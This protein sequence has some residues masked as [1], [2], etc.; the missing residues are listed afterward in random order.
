MNFAELA[1]IFEEIEGKSGRLEMT[2][3]LAGMFKKTNPEEAEKI[4]YLLQGQLAPPYMGLNLGLGERFAIEAISQS[5]GY[6]KNVVEKKYKEIGDLG[7]VAE[8]LLK[9]KKQMSLFAKQLSVL[10]VY[11]ILVKIAKASGAGSQE[12]KIKMLVELLNNSKPVEAKYIIRIVLGRLRLGVGDPTIL[13]GLSVALFG[14]KE[15][16][17]E[18][19]RA[20]NLCSDLGYVVRTAM[21]DYKKISRFKIQPFKPLMPALA[22]RLASAEEIIKKIGRCAV[23]RKYDGFRMQ[24]HK[25][26]INV[27]IY[28]R[29]LDVMTPMFPDVV[30]AIKKLKTNEIIFEGEALAFNKKKNRF[31]SFQETM[32]RRRKYGIDKASLEFPLYVFVFDLLYLNGEDYT[33]KPY[34]ERR[35]AL[36]KVFPSGILEVA[37]SIETDNPKK[38]EEFFNDSINKGLEGIVAKDLNAPYTA[39][40]RKFAWIKLKKSYGKAVDTVDAVIVGYYLGKGARAEFEFGGLLVAVR[41]EDS[42]KLE[43]IAKIGSGYTEEEMRMLKE[44]LSEIKTKEPPEDLVYRIKPDFWVE[45]KYVIEV[46]FDE[47]TESPLHTAGL[48]GEKGYALRFPRMVRLRNDKAPDEATTTREIEEMFGI[49]R[50]K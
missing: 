11:D 39:G 21:E 25:K 23:E 13:D 17:E 30:N 19:E 42:G 14:T 29:R 28:S 6:P 45:P 47:I 7:R 9:A 4:S 1:K 10:Y 34:K 16:R 18:I 8:E 3:L 46:A 24:C 37:E 33:T 36:K 48:H 5:T 31:Y 44:L 22:E 38:L 43:T 49:Q 50:R 12:A 2:D 15:K 41:N 27:Q 40:K 26:G 20:Y 32:H 35:N